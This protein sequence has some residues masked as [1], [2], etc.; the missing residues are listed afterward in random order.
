LP[1]RPTPPPLLRG[2]RNRSFQ[3]THAWSWPGITDRLCG[4]HAMKADWD[5]N[6]AWDEVFVIAPD[7]TISGATC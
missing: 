7:H 2:R 6:G 3:L 4:S 1:H 5:G